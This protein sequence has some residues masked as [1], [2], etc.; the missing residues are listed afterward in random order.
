MHQLTLAKTKGAGLSIQ[1][2]VALDRMAWLFNARPRK[3][4]GFKSP[5]E[6]LERELSDGNVRIA[7]DS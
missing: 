7:L 3:W 4:F 2:R 1:S 6:L 5:Q